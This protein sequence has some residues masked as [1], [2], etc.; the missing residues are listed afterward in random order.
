MP[1]KR[2][3]RRSDE[4]KRGVESAP[5]RNGQYGPDHHASAERQSV[6]AIH[7]FVFD[8]GV[9]AGRP[10]CRKLDDFAFSR[11]LSHVMSASVLEP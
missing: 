7:R 6:A 10:C 9:A 8:K 1:R 4:L 5:A 11:A 3:P 2:K